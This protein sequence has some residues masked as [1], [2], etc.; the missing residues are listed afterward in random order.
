MPVDDYFTGINGDKIP[1]TF[2]TS[3]EEIVLSS[4]LVVGMAMRVSPTGRL[5]SHRIT[6]L[7]SGEIDRV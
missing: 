6:I 1:G 4:G 3:T 2:V 7:T 5:F